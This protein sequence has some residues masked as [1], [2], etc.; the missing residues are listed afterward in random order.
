[1]HPIA[2]TWQCYKENYPKA[3]FI[4]EFKYFMH[5]Q[6]TS[7]VKNVAKVT[8]RLSRKG[9]ISFHRSILPFHFQKFHKSLFDIVKWESQSSL[10]MCA[11]IPSLISFT[12]GNILLL[13]RF[14]LL[15]RRYGVQ[16]Q[17]QPAS[18]Y[19]CSHAESSPLS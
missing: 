15:I 17:E 19:I 13:Q 18:G 4:K 2:E 10:G 12:A 3:H 16:C 9:S 7:T 6:T 11:F 14:G 5:E 8:R 1:M